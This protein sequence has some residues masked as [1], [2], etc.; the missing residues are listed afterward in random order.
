MKIF[1]K[2]KKRSAPAPEQRTENKSDPVVEELLRKDPSEWNS[3]ERRMVKRYQQRKEEETGT[4]ET[5]ASETQKNDAE[6][7][8]VKEHK[9][10]AA[11]SETS[12]ADEH[13]GGSSSSDGSSDSDSDSGSD[14]EKEGNAANKKEIVEKAVV[15]AA[16]TV[17]AD[18]KQDSPPSD[19][20]KVDKDHEIWGMLNKLNSKQKRTLSR[21]LDR[22]GPCVLDEVVEEAKKLLGE[23]GEEKTAA[24]HQKAAEQSDS[25]PT[26][27]PPN[28]KK[29]K[30]EADW[31]HLTPEERLRREEQRRKQKE[32]AE[33]RARGEDITPGHKRPLNS[34][35]R[36]ANRRKPK[37]K[38]S[39]SSP[40]IKNEHN[41]SG[42]LHRKSGG[43]GYAETEAY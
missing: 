12:G 15:D 26:G 21:K 3:K 2:R 39:S 31:S 8:D 22:Q 38:K 5:T 20:E 33:R 16:V 30:K 42:Y 36:R 17:T 1:A 40:Q 23:G 34:A 14:G 6:M 41:H 19:D 7:T 10:K 29:R 35:R 4:V 24:K 32:A 37:W 11:Q 9:T 25:D 43:Q 13:D 27:Q 18:K 28:A